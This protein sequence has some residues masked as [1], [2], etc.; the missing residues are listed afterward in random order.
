MEFPGHRRSPPDPSA[1]LRRFWL[2]LY[3][4]TP[5]AWV[6]P[7]LVFANV[8][9]FV[10]LVVAG[11]SPFNPSSEMLIVWGANFAPLT[12]SGEW[13]RLLAATFLHAGLMHLAFNMWAL[14]DAGRLTER[15]YGNLPFLVIYVGAG[16]AGSL[17]SLLWHPRGV[18]S[19]GASGAVFGVLGALLAFLLLQHHSVPATVVRG[20]RASTVA[21]AAYSLAFGFIQPGIDNAAHLGGL[22]CGGLLGAILARPLL[23]PARARLPWKRLAIALAATALLVF[24]LVRLVPPPSYDY[25]L[26]QRMQEGAAR[27]TEDEKTILGA[28]KEAAE[29]H[30]AGAIDNAELARRLHA[31]AEQW[32]V[33]AERLARARPSE[34]SPSRERFGLL[35]RYAELRRDSARLI[36]EAIK[37]QSAEKMDQARKLTDEMERVRDALDQPS[38]AARKE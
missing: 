7:A 20:L 26:E 25:A 30:R 12:A 5:R 38:A 34:T 13:W 35:L 32:R 1:D 3:A 11:A 27:F 17:A 33:A 23:S 16:A 19:V 24:G 14:W 31:F 10:A 8:S 4:D 9:V 6:T 37:E 18:V 28:W 21:F 2:A 29:K 36:A 15:L 22:G